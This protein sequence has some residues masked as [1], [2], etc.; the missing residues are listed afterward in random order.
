MSEIMDLSLHI[1]KD[2]LHH[3]YLIEGEHAVL[4]ADVLAFL[5]GEQNVIVEYTE[6]FTIDAARSLRARQIERTPDGGKKCFVLGA[7]FFMREAQNALL[8]VFEEPTADTH[9]FLIVPDADVLLPTLRSR[10]LV[11][12]SEEDKV[13]KEA[14]LVRGKEFLRLTKPERLQ[15]IADLLEEYEDDEKH[16]LLKGEAL[17]LLSGIEVSLYTSLAGEPPSEAQQQTFKELLKCKDFMRDRGA[18]T[19]MLLEYVAL[20]TP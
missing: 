6:L 3:A 15:V 12:R 11:I 4:S 18:S 20:I 5:E 8:K 19:K 9:F 14:L 2:N 16:E 10:V 13:A 7:R 17:K 1:D